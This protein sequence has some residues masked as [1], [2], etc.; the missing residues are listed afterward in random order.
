MWNGVAL[1]RA[2]EADPG[3]SAAMA[4]V[5]AAPNPY[6]DRVLAE[7][8]ALDDEV[9]RMPALDLGRGHGQHGGMT[10][11]LFRDG[12]EF[13]A[14]Y[15]NRLA[16]AAPKSP[17][18]PRWA[19]V[20]APPRSSRRAL[21]RAG[22]MWSPEVQRYETRGRWMTPRARRQL[23]ADIATFRAQGLDHRTGETPKPRTT[24]WP[25]FARRLMGAGPWP[26][27]RRRAEKARAARV[28]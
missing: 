26:R 3:W 22:V 4:R 23:E 17:R 8:A 12:V 20:V 16:T 14:D 28:G 27:L 15:L 1:L 7:R 21:A 25:R 11:P 2:L 18:L 9:S 13:Q 5:K 6:L 24:T 10:E 19:R